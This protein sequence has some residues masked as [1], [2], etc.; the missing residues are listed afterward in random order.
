VM[1][2]CFLKNIWKLISWFITS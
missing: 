1:F 2:F